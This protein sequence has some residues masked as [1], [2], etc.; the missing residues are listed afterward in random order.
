M[1]AALASFVDPPAP[2]P[3]VGSTTPTV[4]ARKATI[5]MQMTQLRV[6]AVLTALAFVQTEAK[7][8]ALQ[9]A[10]D[11]K[12]AADSSDISKKACRDLSTTESAFTGGLAL[13]PAA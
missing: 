8:A 7:D 12:A 1:P 13:N 3:E 5:E 9:L 6:S 11:D 10:A 4:T 2:S